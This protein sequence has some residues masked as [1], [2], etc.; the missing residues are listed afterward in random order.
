MDEAINRFGRVDV[1]VNNAGIGGSSKK[2]SDLTEN[3]WNEVI[4]VN[5]GCISL[6]KRSVKAH[7]KK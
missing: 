5:Q 3:D 6:H 4:D 7:V 1:L 2:I